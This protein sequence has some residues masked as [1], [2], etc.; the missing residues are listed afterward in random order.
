VIIVGSRFRL[1]DT[2]T[3][4]FELLTYRCGFTGASVMSLAIAKAL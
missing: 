4:K 3:K 2:K 1:S